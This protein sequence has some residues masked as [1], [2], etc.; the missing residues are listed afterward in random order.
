MVVS[1]NV[2]SHPRTTQHLFLKLRKMDPSLSSVRYPFRYFLS[3]EYFESLECQ[4]DALLKIVFFSDSRILITD[5]T[6]NRF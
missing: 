1:T 2:K 6:E 5:N 4:D 3:M